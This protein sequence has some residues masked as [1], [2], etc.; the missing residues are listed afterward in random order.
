MA[1]QNGLFIPEEEIDVDE[2][3]DVKLG[4]EPPEMV[5]ALNVEHD[6][7][8]KEKEDFPVPQVVL[9]VAPVHAPL[10]VPVPKETKK[11]K[12]ARE[13]AERN[14][15]SVAR[16]AQVYRPIKDFFPVQPKTI[17][18]FQKRTFIES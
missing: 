1:S 15:E 12:V 8:K 6:E 3:P 10:P 16:H 13:K 4:E 5:V 2:H 7:K 9:P 11:A 17:T 18:P 14:A